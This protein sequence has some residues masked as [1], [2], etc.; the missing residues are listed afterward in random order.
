MK[1][2]IVG[3]YGAKNTIADWI[4]SFFPDDLHDCLYLEPCFGS[5]VVFFKKQPSYMEV[6]NDLDNR[7]YRF[8]R[9]AQNEPFKLYKALRRLLFFKEDFKRACRVTRG[10]EEAKDELDFCVCVWLNINMGFNHSLSS[11][12]LKVE[13]NKNRSHPHYLRRKM[14]DFPKAFERLKGV[15]ILNEDMVHLIRRFDRP[16]SFFYIDPP[17]PESVQHYKNRFSKEDFQKLLECLKAIKGRFVLSCYHKNWMNFHP[18]WVIKQKN[19][20]TTLNKKYLEYN[21]DNFKRTECLVMN[22]SCQKQRTFF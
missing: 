16:D 15:T 2:P 10:L 8:Y 14:I 22:Y 13:I 11:T 18:D 21:P 4:V 7:L 3:Y 9:F 17:Y 12:S 6:I 20:K 19:V 1:S 5:G